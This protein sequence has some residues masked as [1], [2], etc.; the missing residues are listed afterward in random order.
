MD[1]EGVQRSAM[2]K[3]RSI[4]NNYLENEKN[5][6][7]NDNQD[8]LIKSGTN[9][10][11]IENTDKLWDN[12]PKMNPNYN[13]MKISNS[14]KFLNSEVNDLRFDIPVN[15]ESI[16]VDGN[17]PQETPKNPGKF[18]S[19]NLFEFNNEDYREM[20]FLLSKKP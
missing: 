17:N 18:T 9:F 16:I 11:D 4:I 5:Y 13:Q 3:K 14:K 19:N 2:F 12:V 20:Y 7:E 6:L 10:E 8:E 1:L 15:E